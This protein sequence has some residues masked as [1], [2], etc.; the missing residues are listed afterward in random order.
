MWIFP[1]AVGSESDEESQKSL[2]ALQNSICENL[3]VKEALIKFFT[4]RKSDNLLKSK[5]EK[6]HNSIASDPDYSQFEIYMR[7][8][9][10]CAK[11][12]AYFQIDIDQ[13]LSE[14][15]EGLV[16]IEFPEFIV[17][18]KS[19]SSNIYN[20]IPKESIKIQGYR[21]GQDE[22]EDGAFHS[23]NESMNP[24]DSLKIDI[25]RDPEI[26]QYDEMHNIQV[27]DDIASN[28]SASELEDGE[29]VDAEESISLDHNPMIV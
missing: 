2:G 4:I 19:E 15:L 6:Y 21:T 17:E 16:L 9:D 28:A 23:D 22:E 20:V 8:V 10:S 13:K 29:Y 3:T 5:L 12:P 14:I 25:H 11:T 26:L 24:S 1:L 27:E 7:K 18:L